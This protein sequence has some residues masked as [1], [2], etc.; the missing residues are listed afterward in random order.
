M[1]GLLSVG[2]HLSHRETHLKWLDLRTSSSETRDQWRKML[3]PAFDNWKESFDRAMSDSVS[4]GSSAR[5]GA[6]GPMSSASLL[7]H[8]AHLSL[9]VDIMDCQVFAGMKRLVGRRVSSRDYTNAVKRM[10]NWAKLA[11]TRHAILHAFKLLHQVLV[12]PQSR[13]R[14]GPQ[15]SDGFA[16]HYSVRNE[17]DP[18]RPW[19]MYYAVLSIWSFVQ[20]IGRPAGR[21]YPVLLQSSTYT[22]MAEYLSN[23][24]ALNVLDE[25]TA[26]M[27]HDGLPELLQ[28]MEEV[29]GEAGSD[30]L[31]EAR[32]RLKTCRDMLVGSTR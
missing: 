13:R 4:D 14:N 32:V 23:V 18:H 15:S 27:L 24:A 12:Q 6:N 25:K 2:W 10:S 5:C 19:I 20:A 22:R 26:S 3:L 8:L 17:V 1:S 30:L 29:V 9:H 7:Y 31:L 11:S 21:G 28:V 16:V